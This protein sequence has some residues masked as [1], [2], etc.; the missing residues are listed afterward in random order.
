[1]SKICAICKKRIDT[2]KDNWNKLQC[3]TRKD[4]ESVHYMHDKCYIDWL[5]QIRTETAMMTGAVSNLIKRANV[6]MD[7]MGVDKVV[8]IKK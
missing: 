3:F 7:N 1:M 2:A 8:E 5:S 6:M 4:L